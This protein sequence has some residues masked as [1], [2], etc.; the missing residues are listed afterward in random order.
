M[1][2]LMINSQRLLD[3]FLAI[4]GINSYYSAEDAVVE[5]SAALVLG[6]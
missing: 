4:T 2:S 3:L 6:G 5:V 1:S